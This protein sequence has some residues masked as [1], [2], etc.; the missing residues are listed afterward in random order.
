MIAANALGSVTSSVA[1]LI[2]DADLVFRILGLQTNGA[3][4]VE[5]EAFTGDDRGR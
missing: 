5:H 1:T 3:V 4:A 2:V